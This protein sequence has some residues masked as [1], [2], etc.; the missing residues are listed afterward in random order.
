MT[1]SNRAL[2]PESRLAAS[3]S[4]PTAKASMIFE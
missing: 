1:S 2:A 4:G 3:C